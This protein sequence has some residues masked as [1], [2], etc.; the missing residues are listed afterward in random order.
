M[1]EKVFEYRIET[2]L[3]GW[4]GEK[5]TSWI[6]VDSEV[7]DTEWAAERE[8]KDL[9]DRSLT[10]KRRWNQNEVGAQ[11]E[12]TQVRG[13]LRREYRIVRRTMTSW[14]TF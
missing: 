10:V 14:E 3:R 12:L 4:F 7:F 6:V 9:R 2:H 13:F 11:N 8:L 5:A 1:S